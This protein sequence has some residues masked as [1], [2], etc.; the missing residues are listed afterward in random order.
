[1][2]NSPEFV[3]LALR[4]LCHRRGIEPAYIEP[5]RAPAVPE[6]VYVTQA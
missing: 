3:A 2:D 5:G 1:M 6:A 4:G